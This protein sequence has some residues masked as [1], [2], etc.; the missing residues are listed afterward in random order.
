MADLGFDFP[1]E[2][3][4]QDE[5]TSLPAPLGDRPSDPVES[6]SPAFSNKAPSTDT[7]QDPETQDKKDT[8][9]VDRATDDQVDLS[10]TD[11]PE[12][13]QSLE[14]FPEIKDN[15]DS[16]SDPQPIPQVPADD[17]EDEF[18]MDDS[19]SPLERIY[20]FNKSDAV[21]HRLLAAKEISNIIHEIDVAEAVNYVLPMVLKIG[22]DPDDTVRETFAS[23]LDKI[24]LYYYQHAPPLDTKSLPDPLDRFSPSAAVESLHLQDKDTTNDP[25]QETDQPPDTPLEKQSSPDNGLH[26]PPRVF[27]AIL[28]E[29]LL[30][31]NSSLATL[32]QQCIV[33]VASELA[34]V[35]G[36]DE[37]IYRGL[38]E[39]EIFEGVVMGLMPVVDGKARQAEDDEKTRPNKGPNDE[40]VYIR[41]RS[42][43]SGYEAVSNYPHP[44]S[45]AEDVDQGEINLAK[46][47]CLSLIS[48]L[49]SVLGPD[50]C[51]ER[52]LPIVEKLANDQMFYVRKEAAAAIGSLATVVDP[53]VT[54][55]KLLP[56]YLNFSRDAIW[57]VRRSC[58]LALPLLCAVL[59][60]EE[61]TN[62]AVEGVE[63]FRND[64]SRNVRNTLA[65]IIGE[66]IAKFLPE[67]WEITGRPGNVP[68][69][70]LDFFLSLG[71]NANS[72]QMFK[73]ET[74]RA[75]ICAYN[76]PA[77]LLTAGADYWDSHL[78]DTY[79]NLSKDYQIKVRRTFAYSLHE[80]SR[81][82][83]PERTERDLVQIFALYLMDLDDVKQGILEHLA[84]FLSTLAV[85]SRNEYIPILAE[86]WDGV[87]TN[88]RL[89]DIL[90]AQLRDIAMLFDAARVVEHVLP[91]AIRACHDE[92]AAVRETGV[93]A[94]PVILDIVK[95]AV[96]EDGESL[97]QDEEDE[98][99]II[100]SRRGF[101][102]ALLSHVMEKLE[103]FVRSDMYRSRLVFAQICRALLEAGIY[104]GDFASFFLPRLAPLAEDP[105]ANVRIAASRTIRAI[106]TNEPYRQE[107]YDIILS[108]IG[109]EDEGQPGRLLE[110]TLYV[111]SMDKDSDVQ[112]FV[113][114][115]V[116]PQVES[117]VEERPAEQDDGAPMQGVED[118]PMP[119]TTETFTEPPVPA[120]PVVQ[121]EDESVAAPTVNT[122]AMEE[123]TRVDTH[124]DCSAHEDGDGNVEKHDEDGDATMTEAT[125]R[126]EH[127]DVVQKSP[128]AS[129]TEENKFGFPYPKD[130]ESFEPNQVQS[131][132]SKEVS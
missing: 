132:V 71:V 115:L 41:R 55:E 82:I 9:E 117:E 4:D 46:M 11:D 111:L 94:F 70:L 10:Y 48:A 12:I 99:D 61:R 126:C 109:P 80:I 107:L 17:L 123:D 34:A 51:K 18:T 38:L 13:Y 8:K 65:E 127:N 105:V 6:P 101:A 42:S 89:R 50:H 116:A 79:L 92:F 74:D 56:L 68:R 49:A 90:A 53:Q 26:I 102:I 73:L 118:F 43:A 30:D 31:Q 28:I 15:S 112:S 93:E 19:L 75:I 2:H 120:V 20:M 16:Q 29:F 113:I 76:F 77:V 100:E 95:R 85:S 67:D 25:P 60:E 96:D 7:P 3:D 103:E 81:I 69:S 35:T 87:M 52:C 98:E 5:H 23:E 27:S 106:Y 44:A 54:I 128:V 59:P 58:V 39:S 40:E 86:V 119:A 21:I 108:E 1:D 97:S 24:I 22:I 131:V 45:S 122:E 129:S 121:E 78:K 88:W 125:E 32:G 66:L 63:I 36:P 57:H 47:M 72:S 110:Q 83:G 37:E 62:T 91:L 84:E 14:E 64:V 124:M 130:P 104:A 33:S 114:D